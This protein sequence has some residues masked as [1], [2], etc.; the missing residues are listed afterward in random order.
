MTKKVLVPL[1]NGFEEIEAITIIDLL[2]RAGIEVTVAGVDGATVTGSH[3]IAVKTDAMLD[4]A[5]R[6]TYDM[7]VLPGGEPGASTLR[8]DARVQALIQRFHREGGY[9]AAI[10]A[11]PKALAAAGV[12]D[13][14]Q[15]T[16]FPGYLDKE[17]APGMRYEARPVVIDGTIITSRGPGT[18]MD[19]ALALIETLAGAPQRAAVEARL[20]RPQAA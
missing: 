12:L 15:A 16:S 18:A 10:C 5:A 6:G 3:G 9:L 1:A 17:P 11:A 2:R 13:G 19:F 4:E 7:L 20:M 8:D 14:R